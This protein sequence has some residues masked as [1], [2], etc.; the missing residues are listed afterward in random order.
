MSNKTVENTNVGQ[1]RQNE[2]RIETFLTL[3]NFSPQLQK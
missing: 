2:T 1:Y 3:S